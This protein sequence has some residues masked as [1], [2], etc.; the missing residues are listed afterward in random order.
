[1]NLWDSI[2][3]HSKTSMLGFTCRKWKIYNSS[4][5]TMSVVVF[6]YHLSS[7]PCRSR[8]LAAPL[9][10][11]LYALYTLYVYYFF[12]SM[13]VE[14][15]REQK[16]TTSWSVYSEISRTCS[17]G[18][19]SRQAPKK[20]TTR[21]RSLPI[22]TVFPTQWSFWK[23]FAASKWRRKLETALER[24]FFPIINKRFQL[25]MFV[26]YKN[27]ST[28]RNYNNKTRVIDNDAF[29]L[30]A[31]RRYENWPKDSITPLTRNIHLLLLFLE[32][33]ASV[34]FSFRRTIISSVKFF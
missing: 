12:R 31:I 15:R 29:N 1:M 19:S 13:F 11:M 8:L 25:T 2:G 7:L 3:S 14:G 6:V 34:G 24:F 33:I 23:L 9:T 28:L 27:W 10:G 26:E 16:L 5:C 30:D 20:K 22:C 4:I 18:R 21:K 17:Y 32:L